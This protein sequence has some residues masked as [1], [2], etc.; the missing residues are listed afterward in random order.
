VISNLTV[1]AADLPVANGGLLPLFLCWSA[2]ILACSTIDSAD[3]LQLS[4][5]AF[6][7]SDAMTERKI[8]DAAV[9]TPILGDELEAEAVFAPLPFAQPAPAGSGQQYRPAVTDAIR[10]GLKRARERTS[11]PRFNLLKVLPLSRL[12]LLMQLCSCCYSV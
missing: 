1:S 7:L 11:S 9:V 6:D 2:H 8:S 12:R 3:P 4:L 5:T 10:R